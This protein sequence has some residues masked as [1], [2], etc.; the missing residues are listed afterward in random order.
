MQYEFR[1]G[2]SYLREE[3][4]QGTGGH[5]NMRVY[6]APMED[7]VLFSEKINTVTE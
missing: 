7:A 3:S 1:P 5:G 4:L 2:I 6:Y